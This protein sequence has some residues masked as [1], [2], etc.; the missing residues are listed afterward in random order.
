VVIYDAGTVVEQGDDMRGC[1]KHFDYRRWERRSIWT[2]LKR[3]EYF[4]TGYGE[5]AAY[6]YAQR[7]LEAKGVAKA[8]Y[9]LGG[10]LSSLWLPN[11]WWQTAG[12]LGIAYM[13]RVLGPFPTKGVPRFLQ[14]I[15]RYIRFDPPHHG[16]GWHVDGEWWP[17]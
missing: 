12:T 10:Y 7:S 17:F 16:K 14:R 3:G 6:W 9:T 11:T 8:A 4:G 2:K 1:L 15:R 13:A 5:Y